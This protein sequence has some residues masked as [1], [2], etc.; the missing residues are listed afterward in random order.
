MGGSVSLAGCK[1]D[2]R[3]VIDFE[4]EAPLYDD[5]EV[6]S[7][8]VDLDGAGTI[9]L[10]AQAALDYR[11]VAT[12]EVIEDALVPDPEGGRIRVSGTLTLDPDVEVDTADAFGIGLIDSIEHEFDTQEA[13]FEP[14]AVGETL[15]LQLAMPQ[16]DPKR[17]PVGDIPLVA[18]ELVLDPAPGSFAV[19]YEGACLHREGDAV[20]YTARISIEPDVRYDASIEI[21][22]PFAGTST[23]GPV[24]V[25]I[26]LEP[27]QDQFLDLGTYSVMSR[28][29]IDDAKPCEGMDATAPE[30]DPTDGTTSG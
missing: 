7:E 24:Q 23:F 28:K 14:F 29:Q 6:M 18:I 10:R 22:V 16:D 12:A 25:A 9:A 11:V 4:I 5:D 3:P 19:T 2:G 13:R 17:R 27:L 30:D 15:E 26:P 1:D 21:G 8:T 20:Q